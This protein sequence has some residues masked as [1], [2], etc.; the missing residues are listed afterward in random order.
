MDNG[1]T[2]SEVEASLAAYVRND[3]FGNCGAKGK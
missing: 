3:T 2:R 1:E